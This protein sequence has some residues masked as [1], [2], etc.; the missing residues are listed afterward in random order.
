MKE[1]NLKELE[2][3]NGGNWKTDVEYV[4]AGAAGIFGGSIIKSIGS[5]LGHDIYSGFKNWMNSDNTDDNMY[6]D[7]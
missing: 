2:N 7:E 1:L 6:P 5:D 3:I 4:G